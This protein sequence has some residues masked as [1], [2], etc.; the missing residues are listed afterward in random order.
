MSLKEDMENLKANVDLADYIM[1][2]YP[3]IKLIKNGTNYMTKCIFH[4]EKTPSM[5]IRP[6]NTFKCFGC[7]R[8]GDII[9]LVKFIENVDFKEACAIVSKNTGINI[10]ISPL[11]PEFEHHKVV[12]TNH[13]LRYCDNL[14]KRP[15]ALEYLFNRGLNMDTIVKFGLGITDKDEFKYRTDL[16]GIS[17]RIT[18][19]F[20][21]C[22]DKEPQCIGFGYR[23]ITDELPKYIND[24]N[25]EHGFNKHTALYG[26]WHAK[27]SIKERN[28]VMLTEGY[29]DVLALHQSNIKNTVCCCGTA[30][31]VEQIKIIKTCT[32]N[33][34]LLLDGDTAGYNSMLKQI[35]VFLKEGIN[36]KV[37]LLKGGIDPADLCKKFNFDNK[38]VY[39][40]I[41]SNI[42][43][44]ITFFINNVV[45]DY[46]NT[47]INKRRAA[48]NSLMPLL[49]VMNQTDKII[50]YSLIKNRLDI[51]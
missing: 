42:T 1:K 28:C 48:L 20:L 10:S 29:L 13:A 39:S 33:V 31:S 51:R 44:G 26:F 18:F 27:A 19:P 17:N 49:E 50:A 25:S 36:V 15:D 2:F 11:D 4:E 38:K 30:I 5:V 32:N 45:N 35:P 6:N 34:I 16:C 40:E 21:S 7:G 24:K 8:N 41:L 46:E 43:D 37:C 12:M 47:V 23:T 9:D 14:S 3:N 22:Y